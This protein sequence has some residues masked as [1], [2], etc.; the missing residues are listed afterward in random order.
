MENKAK[1]NTAIFM[2]V[3]GLLIIGKYWLKLEDLADNTN[4]F[5]IIGCAA[6]FAI[7]GMISL[8]NTLNTNANK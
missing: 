5:I 2:I 3:G 4:N 6:V 8:R 1:K 7:I